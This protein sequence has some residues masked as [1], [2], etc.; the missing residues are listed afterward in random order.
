MT[1]QEYKAKRLTPDERSGVM[2]LD[3][4]IRGFAGAISDCGARLASY[5][6]L[7][8]D[9]GL[10]VSTLERLIKIATQDGDPEIMAHLLKQ[11]RDYQ[12]AVV[13]RAALPQ[14]H[15][16]TI[17]MPIEDMR[18]FVGAMVHDNCELCIKRGG[19]CT[20]CEVRRLLHKYVD[21]PDPGYLECGY[22]TC[23]QTEEKKSPSRK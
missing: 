13:K 10:V 7:K 14:A 1:Y 21:E 11:S 9:V 12:L 6:W 3:M 23:H 19:E 5:K 18:D 20:Q 8:R 2:Q 4:M 17:A 22:S 16:D 15:H